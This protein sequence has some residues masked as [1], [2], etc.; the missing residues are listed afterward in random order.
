LQI[1]L[2]FLRSLGFGI[3][4]SAATGEHPSF[5]SAFTKSKGVTPYRYLENIRINE[6]KKLLEQGGHRLMQLYRWDFLPRAILPI[7]FICSLDWLRVFT[8]I[9]L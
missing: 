5:L 7:S 3:I 9:Y 4:F 2:L 1:Y 6:A 8:G